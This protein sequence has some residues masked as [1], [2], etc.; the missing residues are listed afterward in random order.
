MI[1]VLEN[2]SIENV[3]KLEKLCS[4]KSFNEKE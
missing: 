2:N 3:M 1:S 4:E